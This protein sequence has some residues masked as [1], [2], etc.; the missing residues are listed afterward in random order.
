[1]SEENTRRNLWK[2]F[3][4]DLK[5]TIMSVQRS[6]G[7]DGLVN[8]VQG[9]PDGTHFK[10][11]GQ[12]HGVGSVH[13]KKLGDRLSRKKHNW[14]LDLKDLKSPRKLFT[15]TRHC[16]SP[17]YVDCQSGDIS[18]VEPTLDASTPLY[19]S[20]KH[21]R[22]DQRNKHGSSG[23]NVAHLEP[24][25]GGSRLGSVGDN[26][27]TNGEPAVFNDAIRHTEHKGNN[28]EEML[29]RKSGAASIEI[30]SSRQYRV[31]SEIYTPS[32]Q[33]GCSAV[34]TDWISES[35]KHCLEDKMRSPDSNQH[36]RFSVGS[37]DSVLRSTPRVQQSHGHY[38]SVDKPVWNHS[39]ISNPDF[40]DTA[41]NRLSRV[42]SYPDM[43]NWLSLDGNCPDSPVG[44][45]D[46][47]DSSPRTF[48]RS[49]SHPPRSADRKLNVCRPRDIKLSPLGRLLLRASHL[50]GPSSSS[51]ESLH[52][53]TEPSNR[54][55][56]GIE[57]PNSPPVTNE[58]DIP[59]SDCKLIFRI[60]IRPYYIYSY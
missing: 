9:N 28:A 34:D 23:M 39:Q 58:E 7:D 27:N 4:K 26:W 43:S 53:T 16:S 46:E 1:M 52:P 40:T 42:S 17:D 44:L 51:I 5:T 3:I 47:E 22:S 41:T 37:P 25:H 24:G 48:P 6:C 30:S 54:K 20:S 33:N 45:P 31:S 60:L 21:S 14:S 50:I 18:L 29:M 59:Q 2:F 49:L 57:S 13:W 8:E 11:R 36:S 35:D 12:S 38:L 10:P 32:K 19:R 55:S 56:P 15:R